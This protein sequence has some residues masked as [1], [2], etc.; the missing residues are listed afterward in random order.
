[1]PIVKNVVTE[2]DVTQHET[3][4]NHDNLTNFVSN[5]HVD[6]STVTITAGNVLTGG[7]DITTSRTIDLDIPGLTQAAPSGD[8]GAFFV[9][10][11]GSDLY[12]KSSLSDLNGAL[13]HDNL[14]GFVANEHIDWTN[15]TNLIS[16]GGISVASGVAASSGTVAGNAMAI[17]SAATGFFSADING[18]LTF[19]GTGGYQVAVDAAAFVVQGLTVTGLFFAATG[20]ARFSLRN[21]SGSDIFNGHIS[22]GQSYWW[23]RDGFATDGHTPT[24]LSSNVNNYTGITSAL[25]V[26]GGVSRLSSSSAV[27]I[28]GIAAPYLNLGVNK[29]IYNV[30]SN[31]IT[32]KHQDTNSTAANRLLS[33]TGADIVLG[34]D[35]AAE[36]WYDATTTRWRMHKL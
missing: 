19:S 13:N 30:G 1:M 8:L 21:L 32:L 35:E 27:D 9:Y 11:T 5:E 14:S 23:S 12:R 25:G 34:A 16:A 6:H 15:T 20:G 31:N 18:V 28:T 26:G 33:V 10:A 4:I 24:A 7:G 3:A 36:I 22:S 2:G 29:R 17:G